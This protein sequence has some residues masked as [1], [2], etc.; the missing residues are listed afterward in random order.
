MHS[1][2]WA[3]SRIKKPFVVEKGIPKTYRTIII[4]IF[5]DFE[6]E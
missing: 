3:L 4:L 5:S 1:G 2:W 6:G